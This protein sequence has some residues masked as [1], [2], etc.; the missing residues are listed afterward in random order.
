MYKL[1][2]LDMDGTLLKEDKSISEENYIA[3][4][5]A[6][7]KGVKVVLSTGRPQ[8]GIEKYLKELNLLSDEDYCVTYNG[9]VIQNTG[10][11]EILY[12]KLLTC[13]DAHYLYDLSKKLDINIHALTTTSCIAPK[14]TKYTELEVTMNGINFEEV[15]FA[16]LTDSTP[17]VKIMLIDEPE[18]LS[19]AI[20][21]LPEE[22]YEKYTVVRSAPF[23]LEF[24]DKTVNKGAGVK[25]L[26]ESLGINQN[27]VICMGDAGNDLHMIKYAGLGVAMGN[28]FLEVKKAADYITYTNEDDGVAHVINKF[29]LDS[30]NFFIEDD[31]SENDQAV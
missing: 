6:K 14:L 22:V 24:L 5:K 20:E 13:E 2:A 30:P 21:K 10:T 27:E 19:E 26:A 15:D 3:I 31:E 9:S 12:K 11:N 17:I 23:F 29:I 7:E 4:K 18:K 1:I 8:K 28:A 16:T 25:A